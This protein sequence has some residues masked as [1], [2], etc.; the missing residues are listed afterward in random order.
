ML[1]SGSYHVT[2]GIA[3]VFKDPMS[4]ETETEAEEEWWALKDFG[5]K[6]NFGRNTNSEGFIILVW[7]YHIS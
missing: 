1:Y 2:S 7:L 3:E 5:Q 4:L 6:N